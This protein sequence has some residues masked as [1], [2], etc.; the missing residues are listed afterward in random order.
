MV[1]AREQRFALQHL[2][3]D[4][5]CT[6]NI[7]LYVVLLPRK[8][9]L[10]CSVVPSRHVTGHLGVLDTGQA[11]VANLEIAVLV[12]QNVTRFEVSVNDACRVNIF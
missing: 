12:D 4:A 9:D 11:E 2:S 5:P 1:L 10:R 6:P 3:E 8:H 7:D